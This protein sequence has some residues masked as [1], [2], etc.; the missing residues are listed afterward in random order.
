MID[1]IHLN[2]LS[3]KQALTNNL[4]HM[5]ELFSLVKSHEQCPQA[6]YQQ[7]M[8]QRR[9]VQW[10]SSYD[11]QQRRSWQQ[12]G[13]RHQQSRWK[14]TKPSARAAVSG[15]GTDDHQQP[16]CTDSFLRAAVFSFKANTL[17]ADTCGSIEFQS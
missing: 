17:L 8:R 1:G 2:G 5:L 4:L 13:R 10:N 9:E 16:P 12:Q 3:G 15:E 14:R 7:E 6:I 11:R